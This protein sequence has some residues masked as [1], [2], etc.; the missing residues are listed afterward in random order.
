MNSI[1]DFNLGHE[2]T[3]WQSIN[4]RNK[5]YVIGLAPESIVILKFMINEQQN[6]FIVSEK[7]HSKSINGIGRGF[8][9]LYQLLCQFWS[10]KAFY[11]HLRDTVTNFKVWILFY[12]FCKHLFKPK[13]HFLAFRRSNYQLKDRITCYEICKHFIKTSFHYLKSLI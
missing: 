8:G 9:S 7:E 13:N 10:L 1:D 2:V 4:L 6:K 12:E 3:E 5:S 11:Y